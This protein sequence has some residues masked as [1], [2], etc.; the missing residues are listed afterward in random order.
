[1]PTYPRIAL[2]CVA[3]A[4]WLPASAAAFSFGRTDYPIGASPNAV[5]ASDLNRDGRSDL[6]IANDGDPG[7]VSVLTGRAGGGF[8][9]RRDCELGSGRHALDVIVSDV[10]RDYRPDLAIA[11]SWGVSV[12]MG[13]PHGGF[14]DRRDFEIGSDSIPMALATDDF[15]DDGYAD[16]AT[17]ND[18]NSTTI[19]YGG[20]GGLDRREDLPGGEFPYSIATGEFNG[21]GD[22]DLAVAN[23]DSS[24]ISVYLGRPGPGFSARRELAS[25]Q[26]IAVAVGDLNGDWLSDVVTAPWSGATGSAFLAQGGG[27]FGARQEFAAPGANGQRTV[28]V[29]DFDRDGRADIALASTSANTASILRGR[30]DGTFDVAQQ[31]PVGTRPV[32]IAAGDLE[33]DGDTDLFLANQVSNSVTV[34]TNAG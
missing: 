6:I 32:G 27:A 10:D 26:P 34:L 5:A 8:E 28:T 31:F 4:L 22:P 30:G 13:Q 21:D 19:L 18:S 12:L 9:G 20:P 15:D 17:A 25:S 29:A 16:I 3:A 24:T 23:I 11:R 2:A 1:M 33:G 14:G 7:T